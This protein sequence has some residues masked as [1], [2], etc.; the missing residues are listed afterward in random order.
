MK[1]FRLIPYHHEENHFEIIEELVFD[2]EYAFESTDPTSVLVT[3]ED[4]GLNDVIDNSGKLVQKAEKPEPT[5][6]T[7]TPES[8]NVLSEEDKQKKLI[9]LQEQIT[10][11]QILVDRYT[12]KLAKF[13]NNETVQVNAEEIKNATKEEQ[14]SWYT[15]ELKKAQ[16]IIEKANEEISSLN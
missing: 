5:P 7:S 15:E 13:A 3:S 16:D 1:K 11:T 12:T 9:S 14:I 4:F 8:E 6:E 10:L 2:H